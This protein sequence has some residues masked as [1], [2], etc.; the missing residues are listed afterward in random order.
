MTR[1]QLTTRRRAAKLVAAAPFLALTARSAF[2]EEAREWTVT[3]AR[4]A[5]LDPLDAAMQ[6]FMQQYGVRAGSL[7]LARAGKILFERGYTWS[8]PNTPITQPNS[9]FRLASVSKLFTA[10]AI[11]ELVKAKKLSLDL[12]VFPWLGYDQ[13]ALPDQKIDA[14][15]NTITVQ[16]LLEHKGGWDLVAAKFD[17]VFR[18]RDIA[19]RLGLHV[20]PSRLDIARFMIGE[21]LQVNPGTQY[22]YSNFGYLMLGTVAEKAAGM[23]YI[24]VVKQRVV[25][26][27]GIDDV[28]LARTSKD[29][30]LPGEP[31][32]EQPGSGLTPEFPD[33]E[34]HMPLPYGGENW[35]TESK[36]PNGGL[37]ATSGA[38]ARAIGHYAVWGSGLRAAGQ[39]W[40][41]D[42]TMAG[43]SCLAASRKD[44]VDF[45]FNV[46][47]RN[48][49]GA[50]DAPGDTAKAIN[51]VLD[52]VRGL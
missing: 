7:A 8:E 4:V 9:P 29:L 48:F 17:P 32:Y 6:R 33:R 3:G 40:H 15:L 25:G 37:A 12:K 41:R 5:K 31:V 2:A 42:G 50:K 27:L 45:C 28:Y 51:G 34:V 19:R 38:V 22:H 35:I 39:T 10:A 43:T 16:H 11:Y 20:A 30:R 52:S 46:N 26:P 23:N 13:A 18:M 1:P 21:P 36:E 24:D 49:S 14:R 44:G 47:T